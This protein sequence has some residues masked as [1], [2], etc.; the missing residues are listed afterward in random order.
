M[1]TLDNLLPRILDQR[2]AASPELLWALA[3]YAVAIPLETAMGTGHQVPWPERL[4]NL[5]AMLIHFLVGG[6]LLFLLLANPIGIGLMQYP[7]QPRWEILANPFVWA[8]AMVFIV[9]GFFYVYHRLQ[10]RSAL[11]WHI[12]KLHHTEPAMNITTSRRTHCLERPAQFVVLVLPALW[13][14]GSHPDGLEYAAY[15]GTFFL[16][17][18]HLNIRLPLGPLTPVI[19]GPQLHRLHHSA[20]PAHHDSNF[21][22]VFPLFDILGGTYRRPGIGE[23]PTT[24]LAEC[25]TVRNRWRPLVW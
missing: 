2:I 11:L 20:E 22:Q 14:L 6:A 13:L 23:Y 24:G 17:F 5:A 12:H 1:E 18:A 8:F 16:F 21:A 25:Q 15:A 9:D 7:D 19:V 10:H 4:G 3:I